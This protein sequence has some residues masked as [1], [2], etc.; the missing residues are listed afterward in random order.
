MTRLQYPDIVFASI[1]VLCASLTGIAL[2]LGASDSTAVIAGC[3]PAL[4]V[5]AHAMFVRGPS[6]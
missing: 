2:L 5:L 3:G 6:S 4:G 1:P